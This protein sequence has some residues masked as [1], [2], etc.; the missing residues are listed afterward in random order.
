MPTLPVHLLLPRAGRTDVLVDADG[1]LPEL[2]V[3]LEH[4]DTVVVGLRRALGSNWN[5]D[6]IVLE[7]HLP[8]SPDGSEND[9]VALAVLDAGDAE[10]PTPPGYRWGRPPRVLPERVGPRAAAWLEEWRTGAEPP[11]LRPRWSRPGWDARASAWIRDALERAGRSARGEIEIRRLWGI[12]AMARVPTA[13]GGVAWFKAVFPRFDHEI[14]VTRFLERA[15]PDAGP[16]VIA[17]EDVEGWML[18]DEVGGEPLGIDAT[19]DELAASIRRLVEIQA[20]FVGRQ[21]ELRAAGVP[22]RPLGRLADEV[23]DAMRDP[24]EI[25]G[26]RVGAD[27]VAIVVAW[28]R[29][30]AAWLGGV[31][32]PETLVHGDFHVYNVIPRD[33]RPV[34]IDWS[35]A[36]ISHPLLDIGPWFG[37]PGA[38]GDPDRAWATW[39]DALRAFGPVEALRGERERV[40]ALASAFQLASYAGIVR[41]LEPANRYQLSDGVRDFWGLL[42]ER[43]P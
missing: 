8:P 15:V 21:E 40:F 10:W 34:I 41:G 39:L 19:E 33:G 26:P 30:Q 43:V 38:P 13:D 17:A 23:A 9:L 6:P 31:G 35:D 5:F 7:T 18:L 2:Q 28:I 11:A 16:H 14:A 12:S 36:A 24:G 4:D 22:D 37:H 27:R 29:E 1:A 20:A 3:E 25:E 42:D 32:L